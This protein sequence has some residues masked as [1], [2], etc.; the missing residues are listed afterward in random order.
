MCV[1]VCI[2]I[3]THRYSNPIPYSCTSTVHQLLEAEEQ[4]GT[5]TNHILLGGFSQ[6]R[7]GTSYLLSTDIAGH[8]NLVDYW[9]LSGYALLHKKT[10]RGDSVYVYMCVCLRV[11]LCVMAYWW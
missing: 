4:S 9:C 2:L 11:L 8:D 10:H 7:W 6:G 5:P 3:H 1:C